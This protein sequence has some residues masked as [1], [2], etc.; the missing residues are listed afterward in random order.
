MGHASD[1]RLD[2]ATETA[3][4]AGCLSSPTIFPPLT[5]MVNPTE[6]KPAAARA[7]LR[8]RI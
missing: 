2:A 7:K 5:V 3:F 8:Q 6:Q 4:V 1:T